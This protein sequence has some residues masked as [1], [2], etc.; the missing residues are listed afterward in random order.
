M[1]I[2]KE[3]QAIQKYAR[4]LDYS[5]GKCDSGV[6]SDTQLKNF[7]WIKNSNSKGR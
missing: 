2:K 3:S 7:S 4:T 5:H 1:K 6:F